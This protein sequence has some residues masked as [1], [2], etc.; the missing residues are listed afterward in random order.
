LNDQAHG[1]NRLR[2][3]IEKFQNKLR[4]GLHRNA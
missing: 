3:R 1:V 2:N 4:L